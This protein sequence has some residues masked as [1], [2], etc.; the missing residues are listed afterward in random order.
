MHVRDLYD[1]RARSETEIK[2]DA[3]GWRLPRRRKK[4]VPAQE[5]LVLLTDLAHNILAWTRRFWAAQPALGDVGLY[6]ILHERRTIPGTLLFHAR[7][8]VTLRLQATHP[9]AKPVLA[10]LSRLLRAF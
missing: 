3:G 10:C 4:H 7:H 6:G 2:A 1:A 5:A 9:L 8:L